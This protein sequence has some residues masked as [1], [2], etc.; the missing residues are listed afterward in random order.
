MGPQFGRPGTSDGLSKESSY[1][2]KRPDSWSGE[3]YVPITVVVKADIPREIL[4]H[5]VG[6]ECNNPTFGRRL[7]A[8]YNSVAGLEADYSMLKIRSD[9]LHIEAIQAIEN[10]TAL[11]KL[12][13]QKVESSWG[14]IIGL[15]KSKKDH[16]AAEKKAQIL[17]LV[18]HRSHIAKLKGELTR[19]HNFDMCGFDTNP[20]KIN[21]SLQNIKGD[22]SQC[23]VLINN[24]EGR[25]KDFV[26]G[27]H[28][29]NCNLNRA[30]E[31]V[32]D[33]LPKEYVWVRLN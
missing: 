22:P 24:R 17:A 14:D 19:L 9:C 16:I 18:S 32:H 31:A 28:N 33:L 11:I 26:L 2:T 21:T 25:I 23:T 27:V 10:V 6:L 30:L 7:Q 13:Q 29:A 12:L 5:F 8:F 3:P 1:W 20:F 4:V 15:N